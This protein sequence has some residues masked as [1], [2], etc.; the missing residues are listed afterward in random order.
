[1]NFTDQENELSLECQNCGYKFKIRLLEMMT[2]EKN[3]I[4]ETRITKRNA[5]R[6][7][8]CRRTKFLRQIPKRR[9]Y[10]IRKFPLSSLRTRKRATQ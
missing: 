7:P 9:V 3:G 10:R 4:E 1:M 5:K 6:C 8:I 2:I